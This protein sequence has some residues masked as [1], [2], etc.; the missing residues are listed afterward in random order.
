MSTS[1]AQ[2][3]AFYQEA[4]REQAVWGVRDGGGFPAPMNPS[5]ERAM[6]FWSLRSRAERIVEQVPAY[7]GFEIVE[8]DL[9]G[10]VQRWLPDLAKNELHV[11]LN[12]SGT[13]ATGYDLPANDVLERLTLESS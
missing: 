13:S 1:A 11:G 12:W 4:L 3:A 5:G 10:F 7:A 6:P 8:I 9:T 2:A